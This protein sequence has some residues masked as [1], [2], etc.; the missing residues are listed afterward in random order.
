MAWS[1]DC[2]VIRA[3][4][5]GNAGQQRE[6]ILAKQFRPGQV[7]CRSGCTPA[8]GAVWIIVWLGRHLHTAL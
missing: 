4:V 6:V 5:P 2:P 1:N 3:A 7:A 8:L